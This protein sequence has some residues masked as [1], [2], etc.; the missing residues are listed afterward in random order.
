MIQF[1]KLHTPYFKQ[2]F[3]DAIDKVK[4]GS[5]NK[6]DETISV[7]LYF[8]TNKKNKVNDLK[9]DIPAEDTYANYSN[10]N[11]KKI[12]IIVDAE[13]PPQLNIPTYEVLKLN[14][15]LSLD[16]LVVKKKF[17]S[18]II[19]NKNTCTLP[20]IK[21]FNKNYKN[22]LPNLFAFTTYD[23]IL[24]KYTEVQYR[25][26]I[27]INNNQLSFKIGKFSE[28]SDLY[29]TRFVTIFDKIY[30][31]SSINFNKLILNSTT[32]GNISL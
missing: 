20:L 14:E 28:S 13:T 18:S 29:Y 24:K 10:N 16:K 1:D 25:M 32:Y 11:F 17:K 21:Y 26:N 23:S 3:K 22:I 27:K 5:K 2:H 7:F 15:V 19:F 31:I 8:K 30:A 12:Y 9:I 4:N 6:F